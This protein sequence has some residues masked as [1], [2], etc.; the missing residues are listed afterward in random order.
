MKVKTR[1]KRNH[2]W[3]SKAKS[4]PVAKG[5]KA[6]RKGRNPGK[7]KHLGGRGL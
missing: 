2:G 4:S 1:H 6:K 3:R 5:R 7:T